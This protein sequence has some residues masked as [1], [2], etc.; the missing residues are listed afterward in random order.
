[1]TKKT[2]ILFIVNPISGHGH[3]EYFPLLVN[4]YIDK[5]AFDYE[6][7]FTE[8]KGHARELANEGI[9]RGME[10]IVAV[11][12]DG[13]INETA[14]SL[15]D[16]DCS[17]GIIPLGSGNGLARTLKLPLLPQLAIK[18]NIN[19]KRISRIDTA[20][21]NG[22]PF[23]SIAGFGLDAETADAFAK[24]GRRGFFTYSKIAIDKYL[25]SQPESCRITIDNCKT[26]V[27]EPMMVTIANSTQ[28]GYDA[29]IAP[30]ALLDDGKLDVCLLH[31]PEL[32]AAP[33]V[34]T[35]LL[36]GRI[37]HSPYFRTIQASKIK[38]NRTADA[39]V[40]I[41]GEPI[42]MN[43]DLLVEIKPL[44]LNVLY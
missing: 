39:V 27:C 22:V 33:I 16:S 44:S 10:I 41:D 3:K 7:V 34:A 5:T 29:R 42:M 18:N 1:M 31:K 8:F 24:D 36:D 9:H 2:K 17:L 11:G 40:N 30:N 32:S 4:R 28:F 43:K 20:T 19:K 23:V 13:T 37:S 14:H 15:I 12:G 26:F 38:I 21:V 35:Q 6:I 25:H